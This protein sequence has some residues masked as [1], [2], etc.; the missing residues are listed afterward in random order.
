MVICLSDINNELDFSEFTA[1]LDSRGVKNLTREETSL[2]YD[3]WREKEDNGYICYR[4]YD[5]EQEL[6]L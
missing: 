6:S 5:G 1:W 2:L 3:Y 4:K